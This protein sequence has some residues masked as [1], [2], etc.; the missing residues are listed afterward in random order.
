MTLTNNLEEIGLSKQESIVYLSAL[1]LGNA[2]ASIIAQK[3]NL[4]RG[5]V[6]YILKLLKEKGF[7]S[8][9]I[10]SGVQYYSA[11]SP[12]R[13]LDIIEEEKERKKQAISEVINDLKD[14]QESSI[15]KPLIEIY[16]GYEGFKSIFSKLLEKPKQEFKCFLSADILDY[17][18]HFHEQ[19]RKRRS[20]KGIKIKTIT[21]KTP[22]MD[23]IKKL[24]K[25]E[26]RETKYNGK[27]LN[28]TNILHYV[29]NDSIVVIKANKKEQLA[30]YIEEKNLAE[31]YNNIFEEIWKLSK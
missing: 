21:E 13:I 9:T 23:E 2:K 14:I 6:Y 29:L 31:L 7:V 18:P 19:F 1:K 3:S 22:T 8:E 30:I 27:I 5:A 20:E 17:L 24:D 25:K 12:E 26:L 16:E 28:N 4:K 10:K 11:V 15:E